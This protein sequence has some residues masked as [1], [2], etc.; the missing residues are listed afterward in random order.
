MYR[1]TEKHI[2]TQNAISF[3]IY[4]GIIFI[5]IYQT[6]ITC[7]IVES[8]IYCHDARYVSNQILLPNLVQVDTAL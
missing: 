7:N 3:G 5:F 8:S 6:H 2:F 4:I 1:Y